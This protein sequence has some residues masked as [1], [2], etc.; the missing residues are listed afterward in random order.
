MKCIGDLQLSYDGTTI[1]KVLQ[2]FS[3]ERYLKPIF[4]QFSSFPQLQA[5]ILLLFWGKQG[6]LS[7]VC[8]I[9]EAVSLKLVFHEYEMHGILCMVSHKF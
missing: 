1:G 3:T 6:N 4:C 8:N 9:S 7:Q 2:Q 5:V